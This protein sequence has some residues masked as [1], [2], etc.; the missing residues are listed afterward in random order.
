MRVERG[1]RG[2]AG[3]WRPPQAMG[4]PAR[5][6]ARGRGDRAGIASRSTSGTTR[7]AGPVT[8]P[9]PGPGPAAGS[10]RVCRRRTRRIAAGAG[11]PGPGD[12][13]GAGEQV[14]E[15]VAGLRRRADRR[16]T[17]RPRRV[18][19]RSPGP[20][21]VVTGGDA[22]HD[23]IGASCLQP[24][25]DDLPAAGVDDRFPGVQRPPA[26]RWAVRRGA[27]PPPVPRAGTA[28]APRAA[29]RRRWTAPTRRSS[30]QT[31]DQRGVVD[32]P[33]VVRVAAVQP[34]LAR[35]R[36][37]QRRPAVAGGHP[38][39]VRPARPR[40]GTGAGPAGSAPNSRSHPGGPGPGSA[41]RTRRTACRVAAGRYATRRS[42]SR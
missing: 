29:P 34:R 24:V 10:R 15:A 17:G 25:T 20:G 37:G 42:R 7:R 35:D 2:N 14:I 32:L 13:A 22:A 27:R 30:S 4:S 36:A 31:T 38:R 3:R 8:T 12:R 6:S 23:R 5:G 18:W 33:G 41:R 9:R 21:R 40:A 19:R 28:P 26:A 1:G 39:R 16:S 11:G